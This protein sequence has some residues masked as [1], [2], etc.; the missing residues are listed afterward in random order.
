MESNCELIRNTCKL[1]NLM[2]VD[3]NS[4]FFDT[5]TEHCGYNEI[6]TFTYAIIAIISIFLIYNFISKRKLIDSTFALL[7]IS[8]MIYASFAR[9]I[10]DSLEKENVNIIIKSFD[11]LTLGFYHYGFITSSPGIY[12]FSFSIF[13]LLLLI[14]HYINEKLAI[15]IAFILVIL[16]AIPILLS[17][18]LF[19][20]IPTIIVL[21]TLP[22]LITYL[23]IKKLYHNK[24]NALTKEWKIP[25][26]IILLPVIG[27]SLDGGATFIA[28]EEMKKYNIYYYE[29]HVIPN[30][31]GNNF[32]Y[33]TFYVIKVLL[34]LLATLFLIKYSDDKQ[35]FIF[36]LLVFSI[37]G[38]SPGLRSFLRIML[39]V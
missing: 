29:Q 30:L 6:N 37:P 20:V 39:M 38:F 35:E 17:I 4:C 10:T 5:I 18:K 12:F 32:G 25:I 7:V 13:S 1:S 15:T 36:F 31:I 23:I 24:L 34:S 33:F 28:I 22:V 9:V 8:I 21:I 14:R 3:F 26:L 2:N 27:H 16:H 11:Q 19:E